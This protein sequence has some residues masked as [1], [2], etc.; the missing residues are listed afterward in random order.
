MKHY[1]FVALAF[2]SFFALLTATSCASKKK[3][4]ALQL[5]QQE[6][7]ALKGKLS[8]EISANQKLLKEKE[9]KKEMDS[10]SV[11]KIGGFLGEAAKAAE[12]AP[13]TGKIKQK[14]ADAEA[15]NRKLKYGMENVLVISDL[16]HSS[17]FVRFKT[18]ALF[19]PGQY[20]IKD[21][22]W[23]PALNAFAPVVDSVIAFAK[24]YPGKP[25]DATIVIL[26]FSDG[27][28]MGAG[29]GLYNYLASLLK[30]AAPEKAELNW[31][32]SQL[33]ADAVRSVFDD[34]SVMKTCRNGINKQMD[35]S[36]YSFGRGEEI[37]D[38]AMTNVTDDDERRRVVVAFWSVLPR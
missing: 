16:L 10:L 29:S 8:A 32:L 17:T 23:K 9:V 15:L 34:L 4:A 28:G 12:D 19:G 6:N 35:I 36:L 33:R 7:Q 30:K 13:A 38:P 24:K 14:M 1:R 5:L 37:P 25:L 3:L 26:G 11:N 2:F 27:T 18:G 21:E 20:L 22:N 31:Q